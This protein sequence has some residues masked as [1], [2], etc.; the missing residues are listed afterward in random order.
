MRRIS[1]EDID[2]ILPHVIVGHRWELNSKS[3]VEEKT[4]HQEQAPLSPE[5]VSSL[6]DEL[7]GQEDGTR[8][9]SS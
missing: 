1:D 4:S 2:R 5:E 6:L 3:V 7:L 8:Y 9:F